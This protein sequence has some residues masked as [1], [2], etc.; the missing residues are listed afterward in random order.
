MLF[1]KHT[2]YIGIEEALS[3]SCRLT[4]PSGKRGRIPWAFNTLLAIDVPKERCSAQRKIWSEKRWLISDLHYWEMVTILVNKLF[5]PCSDQVQTSPAFSWALKKIVC[6]AKLGISQLV[7]QWEPQLILTHSLVQME[8][9]NFSPFSVQWKFRSFSF[10]NYWGNSFFKSQYLEG[11]FLGLHKFWQG[12]W[13]PAKFKLI[14]R[15]IQILTILVDMKKIEPQIIC[16]LWSWE[17]GG[18]HLL[19]PCVWGGWLWG[20]FTRECCDWDMR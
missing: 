11:Q 4:W 2:S 12:L 20:G 13:Y 1:D 7:C 8:G 6:I 14:S 18:W 3:K 9:L 5:H 17:L 15:E 10:S 16:I 19:K